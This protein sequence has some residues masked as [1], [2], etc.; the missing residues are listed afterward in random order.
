MALSSKPRSPLD[1]SRPEGAWAEYSRGSCCQRRGWGSDLIEYLRLSRR[2]RAQGNRQG[3]VSFSWQP[4]S[5]RPPAAPAIPALTAAAPV[6]TP[7]AADPPAARSWSAS[8]PTPSIG[9]SRPNSASTWRQ[10]PQGAAGG[11]TSETT[12]ARRNAV[13]RRSL[14]RRWRRAPRRWSGRR[15]RSR[16]CSRRTPC[17]R[18]LRGQHPPGIWSTGRRRGTG[19]SAPPNQGSVKPNL[20]KK[21]GPRR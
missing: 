20:G 11:S 6:R 19:R 9:R 4:G 8:S 1:T 21:R 7:R 18:S 5:I 10:A 12:T 15:T 14:R 13:P 2:G 3:A 17:R 16:R